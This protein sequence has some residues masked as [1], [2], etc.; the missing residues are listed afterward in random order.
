MTS[1]PLPP[2]DPEVSVVFEASAAAEEPDVFSEDEESE[3]AAI[4]RAMAAAR[5]P[6]K[7][8]FIIYLPFNYSVSQLELDL[9]T[10]SEISGLSS[11]SFVSPCFVYELMI[12]LLFNLKHTF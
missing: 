8:L 9:K 7:N 1:L 4:V 3:Q 10:G 12:P 2:A 11:Q 6:E 5:Q